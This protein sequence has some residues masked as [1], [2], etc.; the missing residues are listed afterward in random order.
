MTQVNSNTILVDRAIFGS[1]LNGPIE[2]YH[3]LGWSPG[4]DAELCKELCQWAPTRLQP[5]QPSNLDAH[6]CN[7][8]RWTAHAFPLGTD[9]VCVGRTFAAGQEYSGRGAANIVSAF[10]ILNFRQWQGYNFDA[11]AVFQ[12]AMALGYLRLPPDLTSRG[13]SKLPFP[14]TASL[15]S[16]DYYLSNAQPNTLA[17]F[18]QH[19][20]E[21]WGAQLR[22]ASRIVL[23]GF[24][25]PIQL[26]AELIQRLDSFSRQQLS[27]TSGLPLSIHR[28][29]QLH[30]LDSTTYHQQLALAGCLSDAVYEAQSQELITYGKP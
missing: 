27:F 9:R 29:F 11:L 4:M 12:A 23:V 5:A 6:A 25:H 10:V 7:H 21:E 1:S 22:R 13:L 26:I 20:L 28:P 16:A 17:S 30:C 24:D 15:S 19:P 18:Q 14:A 3:L 8:S 2:G